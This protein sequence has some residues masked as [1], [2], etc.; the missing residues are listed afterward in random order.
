MVSR[1]IQPKEIQAD[2]RGV[3]IA[4]EIQAWAEFSLDGKRQS[5]QDKMVYTEIFTRN[6]LEN[7]ALMG[8][9]IPPDGF[10]TF[11]PDAPLAS[12]E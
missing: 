12:D 11:D 10:K 1:P 5:L 3:F 9:A 8:A 6:H 2:L 4:P 7:M